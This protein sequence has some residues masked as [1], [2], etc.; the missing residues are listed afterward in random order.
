MMKYEKFK[1]KYEG[2]S[3]LRTCSV[4]YVYETYV[5]HIRPY[6][7]VISEMIALNEVE[8][9]QIRMAM[10]ISGVAWNACYELF[11]EFK[12]I[13]DSKES[14]AQLEADLLL[15]KGIEATEFKNPKMNEMYQ[16][17][18]NP[19]Y[20]PKQDRVEVDMPTVK[21][22][23]TNAGLSEQELAEKFGQK[24]DDVL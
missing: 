18:Y 17:R 7:S 15:V 21:I 4:D 14:I 23:Y 22:Q 11:D 10:K 24:E 20:K 1:E 3:R 16:H 8:I 19:K 9:K 12:E 13:I 2:D 5:E 6:L